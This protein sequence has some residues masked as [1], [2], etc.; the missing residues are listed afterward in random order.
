ML[1][2]QSLPVGVPPFVTAN[3]VKVDLSSLK[4]ALPKYASAG[5]N[6]KTIE[7]WK[8][9]IVS[10]EFNMTTTQP[11]PLSWLFDDLIQ[12]AKSKTTTRRA[13]NVSIPDQLQEMRHAETCQIPQV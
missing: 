4:T 2:L 10:L 9:F 3:A 8:S 1:L 6:E 7:W 13:I 12:L 11:Q 5:L